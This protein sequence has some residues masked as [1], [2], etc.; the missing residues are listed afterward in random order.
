MPYIIYAYVFIFFVSI[1]INS[2]LWLRAKAN[3]F[4]FIYE[5]LAACYLATVT[6]IYFTPNWVENINIYFPLFIIPIIITDIYITVWGKDE[7]LCPPGL[8]Y[9]KGELELARVIA[10]IF[11]APAYISG[12]MLLLHVWLKK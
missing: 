12:I 5:I 9:S 4:L 6:L 11:V 8:E 1:L 10:V 2:I 3:F 7:W